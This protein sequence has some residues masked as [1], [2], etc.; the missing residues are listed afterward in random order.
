LLSWL[1]VRVLRLLSVLLRV[2]RCTELARLPLWRAVRLLARLSAVGLL[3][4]L[5]LGVGVL[6]VLSVR[7]LI[8][9]SAELSWLP[10]RCAV[11]L[12]ARLSAVGLL[13]LLALGV[14]VLR[15]LSVLL[16]VLRRTEL[17]G[18]LLPLR[19][20]VLSRLSLRR[21]VRLL[22]RLAVL[23]G[24]L[25]VLLRLAVEVRRG[26]PEL[27]L[28]S[29][30][31]LTRLPR[32]LRR[33]V[34]LLLT[35]PLTGART[36]GKAGL[37]GPGAGL[38][39]R[40]ALARA[41]GRNGPLG[42]RRLRGLLLGAR[43]FGPGRGALVGVLGSRNRPLGGFGLRNRNGRLR[44]RLSGSGFGRGVGHGS[45]RYPT[46]PRL[47]TPARYL[48]PDCGVQYPV[49]H[50]ARTTTEDAILSLQVCDF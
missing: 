39:R 48:S 27:G 2:L 47:V 43:G 38:P 16:R 1:A 44:V 19:G 9:R 5:R 13:A 15:L 4:L 40:R 50:L 12:L 22:T 31:L 7:V 14:G 24:L 18:L 46:N 25:S 32:L 30:R 49:V 26:L 36:P 23:A 28:R 45:A 37:L 21:A 42:G 34:R 8:L 3:V 6:R 41:V 35:L 33:A 10:L 29:I 17:A 20:A 11:R